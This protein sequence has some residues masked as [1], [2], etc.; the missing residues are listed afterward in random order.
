MRQG[1][2]AASGRQATGGALSRRRYIFQ[3]IEL[4]AVKW[5]ITVPCMTPLTILVTTEQYCPIR[6][7]WCRSHRKYL[8]SSNH[9]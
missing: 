4:Q 7:H 6:V 9:P 1:E 8:S 5:P 2:T 3:K